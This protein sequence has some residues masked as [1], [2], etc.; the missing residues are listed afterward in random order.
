MVEFVGIGEFVARLV[1]LNETESLV[2]VVSVFDLLASDVDVAVGTAAEV[3]PELGTVLWVGG[4]AENEGDLIVAG[5]SEAVT[6]AEVVLDVLFV[7]DSEY[8]GV[9]GVLLM[10]AVGLLLV[11]AETSYLTAAGKVTKIAELVDVLEMVDAVDCDDEGGGNDV[12]WD[13]KVLED[14]QMAVFVGDVRLAENMM[15]GDEDC[16]T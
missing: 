15:D 3:E 10:F 7:A 5:T 6:S 12:E 8:F 16:A 2:V 14:V 11:A 4:S 9:V 1:E 13:E